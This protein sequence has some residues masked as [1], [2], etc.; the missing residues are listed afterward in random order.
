[1]GISRMQFC[2]FGDAV[3]VASRICG[4]SEVGRVSCT[5]ISAGILK[6]SKYFDA[7][8]RDNVDLKVILFRA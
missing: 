5:D 8:I 2:L 1:M 7:E 4:A 3:N 6:E